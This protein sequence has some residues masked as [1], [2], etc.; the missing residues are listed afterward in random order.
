MV[1]QE[2]NKKPKVMILAGEASGDHHGAQLLEAIKTQM[3]GA[4]F[5]GMG[6]TALKKTGM[7]TM[8]DAADMAVVGLLEVISHFPVIHRARQKLIAA[9]AQKKP[10]LLICIDYPDFNLNLARQAGKL[11]IPVFYFI[12]PQVWA[13]RSGRV[14]TIRRLVQRMAV[15]LPFE[16]EFYKKRGVDVEYVGHPLV[17]S[18][19]PDG[20]R[21]ELRKRNS[22]TGTVVGLLPGSRR[23]EIATMLP[24]MLDAAELLAEK[25]PETSFVLPLAPGLDPNILNENG[26]NHCTLPVTVTREENRYDVMAATDLVMAASGT[27]TL[28][29]ALLDVPMVVSYKL[30]PL[31]YAIGRH[32]VKVKFAS[33]VNL[34]ADKE[35]VPELLHDRATAENIA[36]A[37]TGIWPGSKGRQQMLAGLSLVRGRLG[38]PGACRRAAELALATISGA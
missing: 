19:K 4:S 18:V 20:D 25:Y 7:E 27:V 29:L 16:Q 36:T 14:Q 26:L 30:S 28:E 34:V 8:V 24:I 2:N 38:K 35:I 5:F 13:W 9:M 1:S 32:L 17:D 23:K 15:I 6:G 3:P 11:G 31:T 12:S 33:L 10:D 37:M 22:L 21:N